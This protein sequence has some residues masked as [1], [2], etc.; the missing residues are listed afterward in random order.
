LSS[1]EP[2]INTRFKPWTHREASGLEQAVCLSVPAVVERCGAA[3]I[4]GEDRT[5]HERTFFGRQKDSNLSNLERHCNMR[6]HLGDIHFSP[7]G[8]ARGRKLIQAL[9]QVVIRLWLKKMWLL[10]H[11]FLLGRVTGRI[12]RSF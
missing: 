6:Q 11:A 9:E 2:W 4:D 8:L 1:L 10:H 5:G 12:M 3:T 7:E